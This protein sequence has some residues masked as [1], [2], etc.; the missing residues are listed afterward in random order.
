[1]RLSVFAQERQIPSLILGALIGACLPS[2][3]ASCNPTGS[4]PCRWGA[5]AD[6]F[7]LIFARLRG[8]GRPIPS[9]DLWIAACALEAGAA[10]L[11]LDAHF[12]EVDGLRVGRRLGD[13]LP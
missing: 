12:I 1:M 6:H 8:K 9:N 2:W 10:L 5:S 3:P 7:A 11:T 13:F 4:A